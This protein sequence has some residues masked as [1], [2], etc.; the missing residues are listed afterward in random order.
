ML[1]KRTGNGITVIRT[2]NE[3]KI[4]KETEFWHKLKKHLND[5]HGHDL[6]KKLMWKDGHLVDDHQYYLRD[7]KYGYC[8]FDSQHALRKVNEPFNEGQVTLAV[9][10]W[11]GI[12]PSIDSRKEKADVEVN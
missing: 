12:M 10:I 11:N 7:R 6:I 9:H 8:I 1:V 3:P 2:A 5:W 4:Y